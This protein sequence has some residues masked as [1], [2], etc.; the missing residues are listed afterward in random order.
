MSTATDQSTNKSFLANPWVQLA[1]GV[2]CMAAVANLQYGWT[3]FVNPIDAKYHWGRAAI[4]VAFTLFVLI[5]TWLVPVEG[6]LVD[7]YGPRVVVL[8]G[9]V[10]VGLAWVI[11]SVADSLTLLYVGAA[12]GGVGVGS[13][14][15]TCVGNAIKWFPGR[16]GLAAGFTA[17]G[18]GAGAAL[19]IIPIKQMID[20]AGY[21][22]AFFNFGVFQG[23]LVFV[24]AWGLLVAPASTS[25]AAVKANQSAK[26]FAPME[27]VKKPVFWVMYLMFVLVASGVLMMAAS[28]ASI[29]K[30]L[31]VEKIPVELFGMTMPALTFALTLNRYFDGFGRPFF[32]W[33]SD[34]IGRENTMGIAFTFGAVSLYTLSQ[35]GANP[36][37]FV[38][39]TAL[40]FLVSGEI[41]SLFPATQGDTFGSKFA[42]ANAGMLYTAKGTAAL[43]VPMA[44]A[45]SA[46]NGWGAVFAIATAFNLTAAA[47]GLFVLKPMRRRHFEAVREELAAEERI[48]AAR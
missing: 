38:I 6:Y 20:A 18:F 47:L 8:G 34:K 24:M 5:E 26:N 12:I 48:A 16:R 30:D 27:V 40:Y 15:G 13:V 1:I 41:Y 11:N 10:L 45:I 2:I 28:M 35:S 25:K 42:A 19:S 4:Q 17:A 32:G 31:H 37:L 22:K 36:S 44:A 3:L 21:E 33:V 23:V 14:Y 39:V 43:V 46:A 9:S 29:A 7:K